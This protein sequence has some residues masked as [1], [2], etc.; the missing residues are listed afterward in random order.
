MYLKPGGYLV[1]TDGWGIENRCDTFTCRHHGAPGCQGVVD[2]PPGTDPN[3]FWCVSCAAPICKHCKA[4]DWHREPGQ[5]CSHFERRLA[6]AEAK[7][8]FRREIG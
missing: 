8:R 3:E 6:A 7:D 2:V 1:I 5:P 4:E